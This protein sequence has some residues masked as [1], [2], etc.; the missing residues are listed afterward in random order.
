LYD[1]GQ[2]LGLIDGQLEVMTPALL[3][4]MIG[5]R[6]VRKSVR[7][8][9]TVEAPVYEREFRPVEVSELNLRK[10]LVDENYGLIGLLPILREE[11]RL[12]RETPLPEA[13]AEEPK[14]T[15]AFPKTQAEMRRGEETAARLARMSSNEQNRL[16]RERGAEV[17]A[18]H[19]AR[20]NPAA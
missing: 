20:Q 2:I 12:P 11:D 9:G 14:Q 17:V 4:K 7:N 19:R 8:V 6:L 15:S 1:G 10:L 16:E 5:E 3:G 18:R 13:A